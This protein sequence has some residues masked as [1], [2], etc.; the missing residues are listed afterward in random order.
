MVI[1]S[2]NNTMIAS[3][4]Q[5]NLC[6]SKYREL[7]NMMKLKVSAPAVKELIDEIEKYKG[8]L[9]RLKEQSD[10]KK[11]VDNMRKIIY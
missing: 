6:Q 8:P 3:K 7:L 5:L 11:K 9:H 1:L 10:F 4:L 2:F